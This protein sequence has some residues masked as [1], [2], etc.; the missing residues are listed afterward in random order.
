MLSLWRLYLFLCN[1]PKRKPK[2]K[3]KNCGKLTEHRIIF[4]NYGYF[5]NLVLLLLCREN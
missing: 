3:E 4:I 1:Y 5:F 2:K